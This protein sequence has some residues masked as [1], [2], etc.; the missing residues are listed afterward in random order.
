MREQSADI[1]K[2][3]R[4]FALAS[5]LAVLMVSACG[6]AA[7]PTFLV[8]SSQSGQRYELS[9]LSARD[10]INV[11]SVHQVREGDSIDLE[12]L[13]PMGYSRPS[14]VVV[15]ATDWMG[16]EVEVVSDSCSEGWTI[17]DGW[18]CSDEGLRFYVAEGEASDFESA[19][20]K[21]FE[22]PSIAMDAVESIWIELEEYR[23]KASGQS[24]TAFCSDQWVALAT[25]DFGGIVGYKQGTYGVFA[26]ADGEGMPE[27]TPP[28]NNCK[29]ISITGTF[30]ARLY[31]DAYNPHSD[32]ARWYFVWYL[33]DEDGVSVW[34]ETTNNVY[35]EVR[36]VDVCERIASSRIEVWAT[37]WG[38]GQ[39]CGSAT[40]QGK[41]D[42]EAVWEGTSG[43]EKVSLLSADGGEIISSTLHEDGEGETSGWSKFVMEI[44]R[45][46]WAEVL[47]KTIRVELKCLHRW[48][49]ETDFRFRNLRIVVKF[50]GICVEYGEQQQVLSGENSSAVFDY[51]S[52]SELKIL[53]GGGTLSVKLCE[54][55]KD[56]ATSSHEVVVSDSSTL[57]HE[58]TIDLPSFEGVKERIVHINIPKSYSL[59]SISPE[60]EYILGDGFLEFDASASEKF[61]ITFASPNRV[62]ASTSLVG[63]DGNTAYRGSMVAVKIVLEN[64]SGGEWL[65]CIKDGKGVEVHRSSG[66][67]LGSVSTTSFWRVPETASLGAYTASVFWHDDYEAGYRCLSLYVEEKTPS[68]SSNESSNSSN[69][70]NNSSSKSSN[71]GSTKSYVV[72]LIAKG[73]DGKPLSGATVVIYH[74]DTGEKVIVSPV[75]DT[76]IVAVKLPQGKYVAQLWRGDEKLCE[77]NFW[78]PQ[79]S[80]VS[81]EAEQA[82]SEEQSSNKVGGILLN[83]AVLTGVTTTLLVFALKRRG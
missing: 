52:D 81:L 22:I 40:L 28:N 64:A 25:V 41:W 74:A 55:T 44:P 43:Y 31:A 71:S 57:T 26:Y 19:A 72:T 45:N 10:C 14:R 15:E 50:S 56:F 8:L 49:A 11:R 16:S 77:E 12:S 73:R 1:H 9:P 20:C 80:V 34:S 54:L 46:K 29:L 30:Y 79:T 17:S 13:I 21:E 39:C 18:S 59:T 60:T 27:P 51:S 82:T 70:N 24:S 23:A 6:V 42:C 61:K 66:N 35:G 2:A 69:T 5:L 67:M 83:A 37:A 7:A 53:W 36:G 65:Y 33:F 47:G 58:V 32:P 3:C 63:V 62:S 75:K 78:V 68:K 38:C 48:P 76:G 4:S